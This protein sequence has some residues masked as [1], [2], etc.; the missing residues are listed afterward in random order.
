MLL[1]N[2]GCCCYSESTFQFYASRRFCAEK[3]NPMHSSGCSSV[4]Q[5]RSGLLV[6]IGCIL[7]TKSLSCNVVVF[8]GM[9][10]IPESSKYL[11]FISLK[12]KEHYY[13]KFSV[14]SVKKVISEVPG[15]LCA[16]FKTV[17]LKSLASVW[18]RWYFVRKLVSQAT[19]VWMTRSFRSDSHL[20]QEASNCSR[21]HPFECLSNT[22]IPIQ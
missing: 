13:D 9:L 15:R 4:K 5:H 16:E 22:S 20:C 21:L 6:L 10:Y 18:T 8:T 1:F 14:T 11:E 12:W 7:L 17:N 2:Q 19:S 3:L